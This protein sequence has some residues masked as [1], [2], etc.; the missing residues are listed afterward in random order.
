MS[1]VKVLGRFGNSRGH[2][3]SEMHLLKKK[4]FL[5]RP[6]TILRQ[7][8]LVGIGKGLCRDESMVGGGLSIMRVYGQ[9]C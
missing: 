6:D 5:L 7:R 2:A 3:D 1:S 8:L 4:R 9:G